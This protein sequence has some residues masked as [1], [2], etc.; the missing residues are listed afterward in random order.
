MSLIVAETSTCY[1]SDRSL[2]GLLLM[3]DDCWSGV[4]SQFPPHQRQ[5]EASLLEL[6]P[7]CG[8]ELLLELQH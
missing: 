4:S 5:T 6:N 3:E 7:I 1:G 8:L 2:F